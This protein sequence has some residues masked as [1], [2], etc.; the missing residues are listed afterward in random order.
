M[1]LAGALSHFRVCALCQFGPTQVCFRM[2][3]GA[4]PF[5]P[6]EM[7]LGDWKNDDIWGDLVGL[8]M[9]QSNKQPTRPT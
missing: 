8:C 1:Q 3:L 2:S 9:S 4:A 5:C 6:C 7:L